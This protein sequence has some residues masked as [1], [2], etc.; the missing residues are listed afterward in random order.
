MDY[1][2]DVINLDKDIETCLEFRKDSYFISFG[3]YDGFESEMSSYKDRMADRIAYLPQG[4][5]HL[6]HQGKII[7]QTEMKFVA[8][9]NIEY[10]SLLYLVSEYRA[11]GIGALLQMHAIKVFSALGRGVLQLSVSNTNKQALAFY[12]KHGWSNLGP[13]PGKEEMFLMRYA[14]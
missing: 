13:R 7:G 10:V 3:T 11:Q 1:R 2:F 8:D 5:C 9:P 6:W 14:L 4:N 12:A